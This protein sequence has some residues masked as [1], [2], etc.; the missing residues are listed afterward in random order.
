MNI[1]S[2]K[3]E[4]K[5]KRREEV[6]TGGGLQEIHNGADTPVRVNM[7]Q[8][9]LLAGVDLQLPVQSRSHLPGLVNIQSQQL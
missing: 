3:E 5:E 1:Q 8:Y 7:Q 2:K 6:R 9:C 4:V